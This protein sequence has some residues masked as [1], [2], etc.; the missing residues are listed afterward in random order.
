MDLLQLQEQ[1]DELS[2]WRKRELIQAHF[3]AENASNDEAKRYLCRAWV[4]MLY[5]HCDN[6]LKEAAKLYLQYCK[7]NSPSRSNV[8]LVWL[9]LRGKAALTEGSDSYVSY[10][11]YSSSDVWDFLDDKLE[12]EIFKKSSFQYK[13]LRFICDWILEINYTHESLEDFCC[14][15]K[16]KRDSIAHG[17]ESY[18]DEIEDC[19][20][21]HR[22]TLKFLDELKD[23]LLDSA[24]RCEVRTVNHCL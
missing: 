22:E 1:I 5:A 24:E 9:A 8:H 13:F 4:L 2:A 19:L 14:R 17:E 16:S 20:H 7:C 21:W 15:L 6:F 3:L 23:K 12:R 10:D 18:V 11:A